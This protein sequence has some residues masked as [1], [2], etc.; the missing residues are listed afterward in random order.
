MKVVIDTNIWIMSLSKRSPY[1]SIIEAFDNEQF[2]VQVSNEILFEYSE[3][4]IEKYGRDTAEAFLNSI[5][6]A[7]NVEFIEPYYR[8][9]LI[10]A[11]EDDNKYVD[12]AFSGNALFIVSEDRHF[13]ILK[14]IDFPKIDVMKI[15]DFMNMLG[16]KKR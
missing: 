7:N 2:I 6:E 16:L 14:E 8:W 15:D 12:C 9:H 5:D 10:E 4:L 13:N 1:H 3:K 11:D